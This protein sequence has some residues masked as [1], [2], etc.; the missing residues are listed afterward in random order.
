MSSPNSLHLESMANP[1]LCALHDITGLPGAQELGQVCSCEHTR[2]GAH[3]HGSHA[4]GTLPQ[5]GGVC[6]SSSLSWPSVH[7]RD[8]APNKS[9]S[10]AARPMARLGGERFRRPEDKPLKLKAELSGGTEVR[11][12]VRD[13]ENMLPVARWEGGLGGG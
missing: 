4:Q 3:R 2:A 9:P 10:V 12:G 11:D 6:K 1:K 8:W 13:T 5:W 7:G